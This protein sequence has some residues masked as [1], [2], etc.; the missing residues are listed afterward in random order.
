MPFLMIGTQR[1]GS[2][3][4]RLM[5]N[6]IEGVAAPHPPHILQRIMPLLPNYGDLSQGDSFRLLVDD[7]CRLVE[8]N[9]VTW[10]GVSLDREDVAARCNEQSAVAVFFAIYDI[11]AESWGA[12]EWCCKSLANVKYLPEINSY[13]ND[14]KFIYLYRDGRDVA[15]SFQKAVVGEKHIYHIAKAWAKSQ[16]LAL[17]MQT[18]LNDENRFYRISYES[19][20]ADPEGSLRGLCKFMGK[21]YS[22][23]ML[24][25]HQ[26]SEAS[27][28]A[29]SSSLWG[30]VTKPIMKQNT[31]KF[32]KKA[33]EEEMI[34]FELVAGDVLDALG[35]ERVRIARGT[36]T[37][38]SQQAIELYD[39][40]NQRLK[41]E[42][43]AEMDP[44]DL[45]RR[46]RQASLLKEIAERQMV[47]V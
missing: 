14:A 11:L 39:Q 43:R 12:E 6:Q 45:K 2:N 34:I 5:L 36:E 15:L 31:K 28:A 41:Q 23:Q 32:L 24:N 13:S 19:L 26:S 38:F 1:S 30:N 29:A 8:L 4:L 7:V 21:E 3:L 20:V 16:R 44:E 18:I 40:I 9:P 27:N 33:T 37:S 42:K 17:Q 47:L 22:P 46:D 10:E 35:Y 25:F